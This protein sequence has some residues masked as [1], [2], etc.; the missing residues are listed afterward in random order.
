MQPSTSN[1]THHL[2]PTDNHD[3]VVCLS[4][5][6]E[7]PFGPTLQSEVSPQQLALPRTTWIRRVWQQSIGRISHGPLQ[8]LIIMPFIM[9]IVISGGI[10]AYLS[11]A[12]SQQAVNNLTIRL[13][14]EVSQ[15]IHAHLDGFLRVPIQLTQLNVDMFKDQHISLDTPNVTEHSFFKQL[16]SFHVSGLFVGGEDGRGV[17]VFRRNHAPWQSRVIETSPERLFYTLDKK[18]E[19]LE[20]IKQE[21]WDP[22]LRPWYQGAFKHPGIAW[23]PVYTFTDGVLGITASQRYYDHTGQPKGVVGVDINL[24][25]LS[26]FLQSFHVSPTGHTFIVEPTGMLVAAS[27]DV[28]LFRQSKNSQVLERIPARL[29]ESAII[30]AAIK[31]SNQRFGSLKKLVEP[32]IFSFTTREGDGVHVQLTPYHDPRGLSWI[33]G[34]VVPENDF[35]GVIISN[36]QNTIWLIVATLALAILLGYLLSVKLVQPIKQLNDLAQQLASGQFQNHIKIT[37]GRELMSL[38]DSFNAMSIQLS[39]FFSDFLQL[40]DKLESQVGLR[41]QELQAA[42][43]E[44]EKANQMKSEFLANMSHEIRTPMNAVMGLADLALETP[45]TAR[46]RDYLSKINHASRSLLRLINDIL[47]FSKI[48]AGKLDLETEDF[49]LCDV[50]DHMSDLFSNRAAKK[51][52]A[53]N[54]KLP[55]GFYDLLR[56]DYLRLEQILINLIG[57]AIKFT[58]AGTIDVRCKIQEEQ[59]DYVVLAFSVRDSGIGMNAEQCKQLFNAFVQVDSSATRKH[60]GTGLGL[61]ISKQLVQ[62][63]GGEITVSSKPGKGTNFNFTVNFQRYKDHKQTASNPFD[64]KQPILKA[65]DVAA[66]IAGAR[67]LLVEDNSINQQVASELLAKIGLVVDVAN[68][69]LQAIKNIEKYPYDLVLMDIQMPEMDGYTATQQIRSKPQFENLA[70]IAMTAHAMASDRA[71]SLAAGMNDHLSKPIDRQKLYT[72]LLHWIKEQQPPKVMLQVD[73]PSGSVKLPSNLQ[74]I[75]TGINVTSALKRLNND[76]A[77]F[78]SILQEFHHTFALAHEEMRAALHGRRE[79]D[80]EAAARLAHSVKGIA[81]NLSATAMYEAASALERTIIMDDQHESWPTFLMNFEKSVVEM[82]TSI[83]RLPFEKVS[84]AEINPSA[85]K[86]ADSNT[87]ALLMN[88]LAGLLHESNAEAQASFDTLKVMLAQERTEVLQV[89]KSLENFLDIFDFKKAQVSLDTLAEVLRSNNS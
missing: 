67:L 61:T 10:S 79:G 51:Q 15:R 48:D 59:A 62:L 14:G 32:Q 46:T 33:V 37:W 78:Y 31:E 25:L 11:H 52:I 87:I 35:T 20:I 24:R 69:G 44:A 84:N 12:N 28:P 72:T 89:L 43:K 30:Q 16:K 82:V 58:N 49:L 7:E 26:D 2:K 29:S 63:M 34:V 55:E 85:S 39:M 73:G 60:G 88:E 19:R 76:H 65:K 64:N 66:K 86:P 5:H 45:M 56:G 74:D 68:N 57:N 4:T 21:S 54:M 83:E 22:R 50:F 81:G 36:T 42:K 17:A 9:L 77:L 13:V 47:D 23:S 18:G 70:I 75:L 80:L 40:N 38:A 53:L 1:R 41:T 6:V 71:K 3:N 27:S 8:L